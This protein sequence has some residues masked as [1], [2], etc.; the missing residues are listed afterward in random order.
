MKK[1]RLTLR[2]I[3]I[4]TIACL[5]IGCSSGSA[6]TS[7][8]DNRKKDLN[9]VND[10][11]ADIQTTDIDGNPITSELFSENELTLVNVW[12]S[13][14]RPCITEIPIL[15]ELSLEYQGKG[16]SI[17]GLLLDTSK[18]TITAG[19]S[20]EEREKGLKV[21]S[22]T[23]ATYPQIVLSEN[24]LKTELGGI[25]TFPTSYFVDKDGN[26]V[27]SSILGANSKSGWERAIENHL[28]AVRKAK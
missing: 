26:V 12:A 9:P 22:D 8:S 21:I 28:K 27:G 7:D 15:E 18:T 14:C 16:V 13:F 4:L 3:T 2:V 24:M 5:I 1:S 25:N 20:D 6:D 11:F 19:L 17:V 23:G 10:L